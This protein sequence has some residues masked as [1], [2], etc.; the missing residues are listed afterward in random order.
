MEDLPNFESKENDLAEYTD[1]VKGKNGKLIAGVI[2]TILS[3][4]CFVFYYI[5]IG[6]IILGNN[7]GLEALGYIIILP[8]SIIVE[9]AGLSFG[10]VS[11]GFYSKFLREKNTNAKK[12]ILAKTL[13][14]IEI[15]LIIISVIMFA[16]MLANLRGQN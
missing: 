2:F 12:N 11:I 7:E 9:A 5:F 8:I 13:M 16:I 1:N 4:V 14:I 10:G 3:I 15:I 6:G